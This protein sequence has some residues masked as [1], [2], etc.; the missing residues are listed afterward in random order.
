MNERAIQMMS[1][2]GFNDLFDEALQLN[3]S[4]THSQIFEKLNS[5]YISVFGFSRYSSYD[6]F[7]IVRN[8]FL[9]NGC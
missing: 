1:V 2:K 9:K 4:L 8:R 5:E 3:K 6:S 7:R